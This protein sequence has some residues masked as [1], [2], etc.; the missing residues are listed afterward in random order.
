MKLPQF[1]PNELD[2]GTLQRMTVLG[3]AFLL[4]SYNAPAAICW[5]CA[6]DEEG[7]IMPQSVDRILSDLASWSQAGQEE[8]RQGQQ[9][10]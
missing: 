10:K 6:L 2:R 7:Q 8:Q 3:Q 4:T 5:P 1:A 9:D